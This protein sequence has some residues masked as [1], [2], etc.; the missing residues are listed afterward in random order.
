MRVGGQYLGVLKC[1]AKLMLTHAGSWFCITSLD[2][3]ADKGSLIMIV[4]FPTGCEYYNFIYFK[5]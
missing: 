1:A 2:G 3:L 5:V 4:L